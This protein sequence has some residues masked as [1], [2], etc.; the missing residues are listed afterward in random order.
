MKKLIK[1]IRIFKKIF[2]SVQSRFHK[3]ETKKRTKPNR[4]NKK[5]EPKK[6]NRNQ[7]H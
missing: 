1:P 7:A 6:P 2:N 4:K 3:P 5:T